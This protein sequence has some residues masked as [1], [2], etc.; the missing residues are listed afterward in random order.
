[1]HPEDRNKN[2]VNTPYVEN[3]LDDIQII[4]TEETDERP[5]M[6]RFTSAVTELVL[7]AC[8]WAIIITIGI[9][10]LVSFFK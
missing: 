5:L 9:I 4:A 3:T 6:R 7:S 1:M 2:V 8:F 10:I